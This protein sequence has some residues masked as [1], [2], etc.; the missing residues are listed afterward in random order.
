MNDTA[1]VAR[2][3][4]ASVC[5]CFTAGSMAAATAGVPLFPSTSGL[6]TSRMI[7]SRAFTA[8][9]PSTLADAPNRAVTAA[10]NAASGGPRRASATARSSRASTAAGV[11]WNAAHCSS[12]HAPIGSFRWAVSLLVHRPSTCWQNRRVRAA[13]SS[14]RG[15]ESRYTPNGCTTGPASGSTGAADRT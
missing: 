9:D 1:T 4:S 11:S 6:P 7:W 3:P 12:S 14:Y 5:S 8:A 15:Q 10:S 2:L 13:S